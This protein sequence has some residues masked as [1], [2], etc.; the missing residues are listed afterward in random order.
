MTNIIPYVID[1]V[2][3][4]YFGTNNSNAYATGIDMKI[5]GEFVKNAESWFSLS[6]MQT[7]EDLTD[8]FY[9]TETGERVEPGYIPRPTDQ[10]VKAS[11]FF[12]DY[13]P[14]FP[15]LKMNL[16]L[17]FATGLPFGPPNSDKYLHTLRYPPYRR[18]DIGLNKL[19]V[20]G[21]KKS[22]YS[23]F[24]QN[25]DQ[26]WLGLEVFNLFGIN[27]TVSYIWV[28]DITNT[29]YAVPNFLT[30]RQVNLKLYLDF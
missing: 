5:N 18:A 23:G 15:T 29:T 16:T 12:Q 26:I 1:N 9:F 22:D 8:D 24:F 30:Q 27:N 3:I 17:H 7:E 21:K 2:R 4:R 11:I 20:G 10:R 13:L 6:I 28:K 19:L 25:F 14:R